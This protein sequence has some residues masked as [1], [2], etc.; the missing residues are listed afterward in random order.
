MYN[1]KL[2]V[3]NEQKGRQDVWEATMK[4]QQDKIRSLL[5]SKDSK[6][7]QYKQKEAEMQQEIDEL[8]KMLQQPWKDG[9]KIASESEEELTRKKSSELNSEK[10]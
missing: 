4:V 5:E 1:Q 9:D 3:L 10:Y 2:Q 8:K 7:D 6:I